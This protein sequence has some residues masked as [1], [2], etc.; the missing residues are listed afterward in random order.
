MSHE[1]GGGELLKD[2]S[3][4]GLMVVGVQEAGATV[5]QAPAT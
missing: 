4:N 2:L 5:G 3:R 1:K